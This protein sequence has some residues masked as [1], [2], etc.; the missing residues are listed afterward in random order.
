[1]QS[2]SFGA[3]PAISAVA[4]NVKVSRTIPAVKEKLNREFGSYIFDAR[5]MGNECKL[6]MENIIEKFQEL[7]KKYKVNFEDYLGVFFR[8]LSP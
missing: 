4:K 1:M 5:T 7:C 2:V 6:E 8:Q 3:S